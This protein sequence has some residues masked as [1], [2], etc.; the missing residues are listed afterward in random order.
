MYGRTPA[1]KLCIRGKSSEWRSANPDK[2]KAATEKWRRENPERIAEIAAAS[3]KRNIESRRAGARRLRERHPE[4]SREYTRRYRERYP[5]RG[6]ADPEYLRQW[7]A[8]NKGRLLTYSQARRGA[9][10]RA[11][12]GDVTPNALALLIEAFDGKCGY[13]RAAESTAIDHYV[14]LKRGGLHAID[15]LVP[16]CQPCNSSKGAKHPESW[17][18]QP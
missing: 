3:A 5:D 14:P 4:R 2:F 13:C 7:R 10:A 11:N 18:Y 9:K 16:V 15:N 12:W 17:V 1:C 8:K 6:K